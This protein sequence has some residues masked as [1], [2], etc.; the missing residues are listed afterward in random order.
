MVFS[1][2]SEHSAAVAVSTPHFEN[3]ARLYVGWPTRADTWREGGRPAQDAILDFIQAI[4]SNT[5]HVQIVVVV[6]CESA[7]FNINNAI[8]SR[9]QNN[10]R[11]DTLV[12]P[13]DDCWLQDIGPL[14]VARPSNK[15][16]DNMGNEMMYIGG[17]CFSFNAWGGECYSDYTR[18][19]LFGPLLCSQRSFPC[20]KSK[21]SLEGGAISS[22]G[23][24]TVLIT[25]ECVRHR[26]LSEQTVEKDLHEL[27]GATK[28]IWLPYG[29]QY[30][31]DTHGHVDNIAVFIASNR[32]VLLWESE[33]RSEKVSQ[34][35]EDEDIIVH[36]VDAPGVLRRT[37]QEA[38]GVTGGSKARSRSSG[39]ELCASYTNFVVLEDTVFAPKF[40]I[41]EADERARKQ[42]TE[43]FKHGGGKKVVMVPARELILAGGG[44]HCISL[45][46]PGVDLCKNKNL[47]G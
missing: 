4:L 12:I 29:A 10:K 32:V 11:V 35:L 8:E 15:S 14:L 30:D 9:S 6:S 19:A 25:R 39:E 37:P 47:Q 40:G 20:V 38:S 2:H 16:D 28:V 33:E 42:L 27:I 1:S 17:V 24:G 31:T 36:R 7:R 22:N 46:E 44:L 18:D 3:V 41:E 43:A 34:I 13:Y 26:G 45:G 23:K 5:T 21:L